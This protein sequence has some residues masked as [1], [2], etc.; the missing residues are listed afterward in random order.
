MKKR[1]ASIG[2]LIV[3]VLGLT[4]SA[5]AAGERL[6]TAPSLTFSGTTATCTATI[7]S[8]G[9]KINATMA[10][11]Q[12]GTLVGGPW[13]GSGTGSFT[14]PKKT[15]RIEHGK[16]YTLKVYGTAGGDSF[17]MPTYTKTAP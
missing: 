10:L 4:V 9:K 1:L 2:L 7:T 13:S 3:M 12:G 11:Y 16:T 6:S 15:C 17:T 14:F 5:Y 8:S